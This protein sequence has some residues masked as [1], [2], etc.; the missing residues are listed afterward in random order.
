MLSALL[1]VP[2]PHGTCFTFL[3]FIFLSVYWLLRGFHPGILEM[4]ISCYNEMNPL[5]DLLFLYRPAPH[6]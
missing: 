2:S 3:S 5:Y 4:H 1:L 6:H